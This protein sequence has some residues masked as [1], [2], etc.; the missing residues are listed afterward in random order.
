VNPVRKLGWCFNPPSPVITR[1]EATKQSQEN[2][3][4]SKRGKGRFSD[5][6]LSATPFDDLKRELLSRKYSYKIVKGY[7]YYNRDFLNFIDKNP[8]DIQ[9]SDIMEGIC[10]QG[11]SKKY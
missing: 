3:S 1:T 10:Q 4:L 5:K 7:L 9:E 8:F 2:P 11:Q 6:K